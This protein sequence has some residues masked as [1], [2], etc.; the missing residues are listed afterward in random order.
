M[1]EK[2]YT[3]KVKYSKATAGQKGS[4]PSGSKIV[5][6]EVA[7]LKES[8]WSYKKLREIFLTRLKNA[9]SISQGENSVRLVNKI[10]ES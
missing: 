4:Y 8:D 5:S 6:Y 7:A 3:I 1:V 2:T 9:C 10:T